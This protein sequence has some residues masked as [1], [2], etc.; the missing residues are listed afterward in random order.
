MPLVNLNFGLL[1]SRMLDVSD[2]LGA[3]ECIGHFRLAIE[4][5]LVKVDVLAKQSG[6]WTHWRNYLEFRLVMA[7]WRVLISE[8][9]L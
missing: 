6:C 8:N 7:D 5:V 3:N 4:E 1:S 9:W 2:Q